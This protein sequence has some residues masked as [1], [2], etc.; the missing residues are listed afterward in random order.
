MEHNRRFALCLEHRSI[1]TSPPIIPYHQ[2]SPLGAEHFVGQAGAAVTNGMA[3]S[4]YGNPSLA[5]PSP[6][7]TPP[8][9]SRVA[10]IVCTAAPGMGICASLSLS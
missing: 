6:L 4:L 3:I 2:T 8:Q 10:G 7:E 9:L 5:N 1:P